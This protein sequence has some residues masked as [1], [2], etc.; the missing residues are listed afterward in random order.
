VKGK[1]VILDKS[2]E[3]FYGPSGSYITIMFDNY[4]PRQTVSLCKI[5]EYRHYM[6]EGLNLVTGG[7]GS[8]KTANVCYNFMKCL[9][10][11]V[12]FEGRYYRLGEVASGTSFIN[13]L[14]LILT[15]VTENKLSSNSTQVVIIDSIS[16]IIDLSEGRLLTTGLP[17]TARM[18]ILALN[19][20]FS[21]LGVICVATLNNYMETNLSSFVAQKCMSV[22]DLD[23][24]KSLD[25][26][27]VVNS[28]LLGFIDSRVSYDQIDKTSSIIKKF[29][30]DL[31][32]LDEDSVKNERISNSFTEDEY[33]NVIVDENN[34]FI[35]KTS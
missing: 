22:L 34:Q 30:L 8:G 11:N 4:K 14:Y 1:E 19:N 31:S 25:K 20:L 6:C 26:K 10:S 5:A 33:E 27:V 3:I 12:D 13:L 7:P 9:N 35:F 23:M 16:D 29:N 21:Y 15:D 18:S 28:N 32:S 17:N 24:R 2:K